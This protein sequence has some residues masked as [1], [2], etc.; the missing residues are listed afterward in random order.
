MTTSAILSEGLMQWDTI[1]NCDTTSVNS[2]TIYGGYN[3]FDETSRITYQGNI[4]GSVLTSL[5]PHYQ[6]Q[7][8]LN[9]Y[10]AYP[11]TVTAPFTESIELSNEENTFKYSPTDSSCSAIT[12]DNTNSFNFFI[13]PVSLIYKHNYDMVT[14]E[15]T[16]T[17]ST[18]EYYWGITQLNF[19]TS[20]CFSSSVSCLIC[21]S[22]SSC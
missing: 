19:S 18:T 3:C 1:L 16:G 8:D 14:L 13:C 2:N 7:V 12:V 22:A 17:T 10:F 21:S 9:L 20:E 15:I 11:T 4:V 6:L 5:A